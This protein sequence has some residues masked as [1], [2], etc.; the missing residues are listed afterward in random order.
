MEDNLT[1]LG[2]ISEQEYI[3]INSQVLYSRNRSF[4]KWRALSSPNRSPC[5]GLPGAM[6]L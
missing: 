4:T 5:V 6:K 3:A 2:E 1:V